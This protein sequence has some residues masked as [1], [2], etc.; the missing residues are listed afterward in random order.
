[1]CLVCGQWLWFLL[2]L[3]VEY[4]SRFYVIIWYIL[5]SILSWPMIPTQYLCLLL[6]PT[7]MFLSLLFVECSKRAIDFDSTA[8]LARLQHNQISGWAI[9]PSS[10]WI[11]SFTSWCL[12]VRTWTISFAYFSFLD[13]LCT[14]QNEPRV[15]PTLILLCER[16]NQSK[17]QHFNHNK[18]KIMRNT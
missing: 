15:A 6:T 1:M 14:T 17:P 18:R 7:C 12:E 10:D 8:T 3:S 13:T 9:V 4:G 2:L 16:T 5:L 11:L